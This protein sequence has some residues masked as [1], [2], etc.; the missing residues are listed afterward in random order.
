[1][2]LFPYIS[3]FT[4][5]SASETLWA[6]RGVS[7]SKFKSSTVDL[8]DGRHIKLLSAPD[9]AR[10]WATLAAG[11]ERSKVKLDDMFNAALIAKSMVGKGANK[12]FNDLQKSAKRLHPD[13]DDAWKE[14]IPIIEEDINYN[15]GWGH[16]H[17]DGTEEGFWRES[18]GMIDGD[19]HEAFMDKFYHQ[20]IEDSQQREAEMEERYQAAAE[21][22]GVS[23][24]TSIVTE[25]EMRRRDA[26]DWAAAQQERHSSEDMN[27][28][29]NAEDIMARRHS[30]Y[31]RGF[32]NPRVGR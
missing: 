26:L 13:I 7:L 6:S 17:Q 27:G 24:S 11:R 4:T 5:T 3:A 25:A 29:E 16:A 23:D 12:L 15:D 32:S 9:H 1:M 10:L 14:I 20:Q 30:M 22:G 2:A 28:D 21:W 18:Q 31:G 8:L 19:K